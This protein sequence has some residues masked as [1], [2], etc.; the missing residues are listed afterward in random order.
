M[1]PE[2]TPARLASSNE[3]SPE[4]LR[5]SA[6]EVQWTSHSS[7]IPRRN[8]HVKSLNVTSSVMSPKKFGD[9]LAHQ[10]FSA[11]NSI[12]EIIGLENYPGRRVM[13]GDNFNVA[14]DGIGPN[15]LRSSILTGTFELSTRMPRLPVLNCR[16]NA[17]HPKVEFL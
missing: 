9:D 3:K 8:R 14:C 17:A 7:K 15:P 1:S 16:S 2:Y 11:S 10:G 6:S 5:V 12:K 4:S 13:H